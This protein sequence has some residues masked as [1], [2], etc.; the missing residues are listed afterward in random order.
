MATSAI[1]PGFLTQTTVFTQKM[2]A[3]F[4]F[5]IL[6]SIVLDVIAQM[7]VWRT[8]S[9]SG[10]RAN[11][12]ADGVVKGAGV[13]LAVAVAGGGLAFNIGNVAGAGLGLNALMGVDPI[14]GAIVTAGIAV[15]LFLMKDAIRAVDAFV[16]VCGVVMVGLILTMVAQ[17]HPPLAS[18][19]RATLV[20]DVF[21]AR[22]VVTLVGGTVG[23]YITFAGAHRLVDAG[24]VG[25]AHLGAVTR[26]AAVG[27]SVTA[28]IRY[29]LFLGTLGVIV[30]GGVLDAQNPTSSVFELSF[31][32]VGKRAFGLMMWAAAITSV[33]GSAY[34][35]ISF[36][37]ALHPRIANSR[38]IATVVFIGVSTVVFALFGKPVAVLVI[39]G[40]V[41]GFILPFALALVLVAA[42]KAAFMGTHRDPMTLVVLGWG[43]VFVTGWL[44][45]S[46]LF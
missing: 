33:I 37:S 23:G 31:G 7:A 38:G 1:G 32:D 39:A 45:I 8:V 18:T 28:L 26:S 9:V 10:K 16:R 13:A 29:L 41:N 44:A 34:T 27:I 11:E 43:V 24:L 22:T 5:V 25:V 17:S 6:L 30:G 2:G 40:Y 3:S 46:S 14:V 15:V 19:L 12:L 35:S 36:L 42:R 4:G 21:D 20:P